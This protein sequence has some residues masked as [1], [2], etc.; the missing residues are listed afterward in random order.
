MNELW[1]PTEVPSYIFHVHKSS[2]SLKEQNTPHADTKH[3]DHG[4]F[5]QRNAKHAN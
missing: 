2:S 3:I 5:Q 4:E 1:I